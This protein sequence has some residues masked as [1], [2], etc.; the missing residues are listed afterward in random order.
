MS[1]IAKITLT[2]CILCTTLIAGYLAGN[3]ARLPL[4]QSLKKLK[5]VKTVK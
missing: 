2:A 4:I 3:N 5:T 1:L